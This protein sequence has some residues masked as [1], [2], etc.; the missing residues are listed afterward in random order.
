MLWFADLTIG[1][2]AF[3]RAGDVELGEYDDAVILC[4]LGHVPDEIFEQ[5]A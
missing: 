1:M 4:R 2:I 5:A 3:S